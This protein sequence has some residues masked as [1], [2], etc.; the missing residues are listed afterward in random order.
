MREAL[1]IF[2]ILLLSL[3]GCWNRSGPEVVVYAALD[4]PFSEPALEQFTEETGIR[5][6][7]SYDTE[8]T[9]TVGLTSR[10][11]AERAR[12]R[13]DLFWNNEILNTLRLQEQGLLDVYTS[14]QAEH[15]PRE[16]VSPH[17]HWHGFAARVRV[18]IV[19]TDKLPRDEW[20][21]SIRDLIDPK[22]KGQIG[23]A[24]PLF[25]TTATHA[26][27]L[28]DAWGDEGAKEFFLRL[29]DNAKVL[30]GNKQVAA[31]VARGE[32]LFG[33]TDTDDA[34]M[35]KSKPG[36]PVE[37]IYPDQGDNQMGALFIPNTLAIIKGGPNAEQA[38]KLVDYLLTAQVE[39]QLATS[40]SAQFPLHDEARVQP[41]AAPDAPL[42]RMKIDF[43]SAAKKW[44]TAAAFLKE[45]F[46]TAE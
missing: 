20:P 19:N 16:F 31:A 10:I 23:I 29:K 24:K 45:H 26:A 36:T 25:G 41:P 44:D 2:A 14:P 11:M 28:F 37:I 4:R 38:R 9:K 21:T 3:G 12:P 40:G 27:C 42:K 13:C 35:E 7:A 17:G 1:V 8:S 32:L 5:V 43:N 34:F 18:L 33:L 39:G 46:A 22:Y 15:Y 6:L 30:S